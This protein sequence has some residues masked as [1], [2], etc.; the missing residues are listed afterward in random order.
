M[1]NPG[2]S[3]KCNQT[4][5][6]P[7]GAMVTLKCTISYSDTMQNCKGIKYLWCNT[8]GEI[9]SNNDSLNYS[10]EWDKFTYVSL[11]ISSVTEGDNY[12]VHID[13]NCGMATSPAIIVTVTRQSSGE[14]LP[15]SESLP[16][17]V[18]E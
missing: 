3:L 9:S 17:Y 14:W 6:V 16:T 13:T 7:S 8:H 18:C 12:T 5:E 4:V 2:V 15:L 10:S 11:T 1:S